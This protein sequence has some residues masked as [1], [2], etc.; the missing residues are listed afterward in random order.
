MNGLLKHFELKRKLQE[1]QGGFGLGRSC[2]DRI[3]PF[4][5]S[6]QGRT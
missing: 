1:G 5:E 2:I 3:F 6:I 4:D